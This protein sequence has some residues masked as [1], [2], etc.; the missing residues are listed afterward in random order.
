MVFL[1]SSDERRF[2]QWEHTSWWDF[3]RAEDKSEEYQK[4]I[5][6]GLTRT[7]VAAKETVASTR[8][9]GN[10]AEA[11]VMNIMNRGNDGAP[12]RVLNAPDRRGL[13]RPL[14]RST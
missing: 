8:T 2:G 10:M 9:I 1:T 14:G 6:S 5:A 12:D 13:D 11:F 7:V 3:V 4:V